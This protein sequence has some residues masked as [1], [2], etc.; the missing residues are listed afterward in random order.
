MNP[1]AGGEG[2][3]YDILGDLN[4]YAVGWVDWNMMLDWQGKKF[5]MLFFTLLK[6]GPNHLNNYCDSPILADYLN[7]TIH[8]QPT[9]I[10]I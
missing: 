5:P 8:F 9:V 10:W 6:G 1:R 3:A 2:Y 7:Q 4:S